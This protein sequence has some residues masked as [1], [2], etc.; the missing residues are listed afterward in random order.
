M[1]W[2]GGTLSKVWRSHLGPKMVPG[3]SFVINK[4][5]SMAWREG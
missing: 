4:Y 2:G 5:L 1:L 3:A